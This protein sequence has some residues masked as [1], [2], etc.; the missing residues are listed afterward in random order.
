MKKIIYLSIFALFSVAVNAQ[1]PD[2]KKLDQYFDVLEKNN[3]FMGSVALAQNGKIIYD[4]SIGFIDIENQ[5]KSDI[6]TK[7]RIG[8]ISKTFTAVLVLK[9]VEEKKLSLNQTLDKYYPQI[10]NSDKISIS[11][12][13]YHRSGINNFTDQE[14]YLNWNSE[15]KSEKEMLNI[16]VKGG[17]DFQPN[18]K[19]EYSNSNFL[20]LSYILEKI[21]G[22]KFAD[23]L[24]D[25][26]VKKLKLKNTYLGSKIR[27][28]FQE[29]YSYKFSNQF[30]LEKETDMSIPIGAGAVVSNPGD[31]TIFADALFSGKLISKKSLKLMK[32]INGSFAMGLFILPFYDKTAYGHT[33]G[34]DG[35]SSIFC[36]FEKDKIA[37]A[38]NSNGTRMNNNDISI[39]VLSAAFGKAFELPNFESLQLKAED[40]DIYLGEY[41]SN[42]I[43][44]NIKITKSGNSL[45]AQAT[46]QA[47]FNLEASSK[48]I[49]TFEQAGVILEFNPDKK[50]LTLKQGGGVF[51]FKKI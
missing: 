10:K 31:L 42:D 29:S 12:L 18:S 7:Y 1:K 20:L 25:K 21:Y 35:F 2:T 27:T 34:I 9:A 40:L 24:N 49:F 36:Y 11:D 38:L 33:G 39:A 15:A 3:R 14:D 50:E 13:L 46:G 5:I 41:S 45:V 19:S 8:S 4:R 17:I 48:H 16:I 28:N 32:T 23:L 37:Y 44:L 22:E 43:P 30:E 26:I 6:N 51:L 47:S